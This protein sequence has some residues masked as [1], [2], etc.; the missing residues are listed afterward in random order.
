[1]V[2]TAPLKETVVEATTSRDRGFQYWN[3]LWDGRVIAGGYRDRA[4]EEEV[5]YHAAPTARLQTYLDDHVRALGVSAPVTH[6]WAGIM[7]FTEDGLPIVGPVLGRK[8]LYVCGGYNGGGM[9]YAF[10]CARR[11][12]AHLVG[13]EAGPLVP[14]TDADVTRSPERAK[15]DGG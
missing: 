8:N 2:A 15:D 3:Q 9:S 6:R 13:S 4:I 12:A 11:L 7:G 14:W 5:G 10:H 1:M